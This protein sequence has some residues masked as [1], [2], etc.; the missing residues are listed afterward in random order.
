MPAFDEEVIGSIYTRKCDVLDPHYEPN[1][2]RV[3]R[4]AKESLVNSRLI[5]KS[6]IQSDIS[7]KRINRSDAYY[8]TLELRIRLC[9]ELVKAIL[10]LSLAIVAFLR[11]MV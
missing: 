2:S 1:T 10:L 7:K 5:Y 3:R 4:E 8:Y 11:I 6:Y 9:S